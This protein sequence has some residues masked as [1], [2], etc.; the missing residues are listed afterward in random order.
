MPRFHPAQPSFNAGELSPRLAARVDFSKY[1]AGLETCQNLIPLPEGGVTRRPASRYVAAAEDSSVKSRLKSFEASSSQQHILEL[2]DLKMRFYY[3]QAQLAV[4]ETDAAITNGTFTSGITDWDDRS[5][6]GAGNQIS[7]DATNGRLTL[8]T[9]GAASSDI[10]WAEQDVTTTDT[11]QE[12]VIKFKVIGVPGDKIQFQVGST[13]TGSEILS[14][15][16][17]SIGYH[18]VAFTP[19]ASPFYIQF[20]SIGSDNLDKDI[21]IDDV[22]LI[23]GDAV[24]IDSPYLEATLFEIMGAQSADVQYLCYAEVAPYKLERLGLST[25]SLVRVAWQDGPYL[26]TNTTTTTLTP[27][28]TSGA[29]VTITASSTT[30]INDGQGFLATDVYR[31]LRIDNPAT[32]VA[33]GWGIITGVTNT[34]TVTVAVKRD[35]STTN[36]D[37][38]WRLGAWSDTT[39]WPHAATFFEQRIYTANTD[40][41]PQTMWASQT[42]DF[43]NMTPDDFAGTVEDDDALDFT[44]SAD[45]INAI[46]WL[47]AGEDTLSIG[48]SGGEWIPSA[49]GIVI[50]P[51]DI[52][53]RRQTT[54]GSA[55]TT[56]LRVGQVVLFIQKSKRK[57]REFGFNFEVDGYLAPDMTRLAQHITKPSLVE[58]AYQEEPD[59]LV[60][61]VRSDGVLISMT[62]RRDEDVVGW[63]RH[64]FGGS[65]GSGAAVVESVAT[66][67]GADDDNQVQHSGDRN[68]VWVIVKRTINSQTKRYIEVLEGYYDGDLH[69]QEDAYYADSIITYDGTSTATIT[70]LDHLEG[71]TVK[72]WGDGAVFPDATVSSGQI[73]LDTE[74]SVAQIGLAYTHRGKTLK[75]EGGNPAG[76][77]LG[78]KKRIYGVTFIVLESHTLSYGPDISNLKDIDFRVVADEMDSAAPL[79]TGER[80]VQFSGDWKTDTRIVF[81]SEDPAPFTLLAIAPEIDINPLK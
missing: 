76:T 26:P 23:S 25:W 56:P 60:W 6:G 72:V 38:N 13:S 74:V 51:L 42:A 77:A 54:H 80:F 3:R 17:K 10:G 36:A 44:L 45:S 11:N 1:P 52:T 41:Q 8:E 20:R 70:G 48:T 81:E 7:H 73:T 18:C 35:F 4:A 71:E 28:A 61:A 69:D 27:G 16:E 5:T 59:S 30:G 33:W 14:P 43:E 34:T 66:I 22:S 24:E 2:D 50:T 49:S 12:H 57:V 55:L 68:E 78:K 29:A 37:V 9:S 65:F 21:Q 31:L 15:V 53:I 62:Y 39:G 75:V 67:V 46:N 32:G 63:A 64:V 19:T 79:F 47:S 40:N 58:M